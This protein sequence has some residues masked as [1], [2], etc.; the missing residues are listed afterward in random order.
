MNRKLTI[1][2]SVIRC[3]A[4]ISRNPNLKL[5]SG[6]ECGDIAEEC[7]LKPVQTIEKTAVPYFWSSDV[8]EAISKIEKRKEEMEAIRSLGP[9]NG[10][11]PA[12]A[13]DSPGEAISLEAAGVFVNP[14]KIPESADE[15]SQRT[16]TI[17]PDTKAHTGPSTPTA[18][19]K[20][21]DSDAADESSGT[22]EATDGPAAGSFEAMGLSSQA[23]K[24]LEGNG[25][26]SVNALRKLHDVQ[27]DAGIRAL[28]G[29]GEKIAK[30]IIDA[31]APAPA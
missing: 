11:T 7:N 25:V 3:K 17:A 13:P 12:P 28:D 18:D 8:S 21:D 29:V 10:P 1:Y 30:Q 31:M 24:A 14:I 9:L 23:I 15:P 19:V 2:D 26:E 6:S 16:P 20:D 5:I 4:M 27:G 22:A